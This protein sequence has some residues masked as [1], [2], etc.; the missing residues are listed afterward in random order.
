MSAFEYLGDCIEQ[1]RDGA[2]QLLYWGAI[3]DAIREGREA[4]SFGRTAASNEGLLEYKR[5]WGTSE[6]DLKTLISPWGQSVPGA[7]REDCWKYRLVRWLSA[8][9][10]MPLYRLLG[11][12]CYRHMG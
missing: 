9:A 3:L 6:S 11:H 10:P 2:N 7:L 5:R 4:F 1:R 12:F 8:N